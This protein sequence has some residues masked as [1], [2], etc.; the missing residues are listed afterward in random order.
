MTRLLRECIPPR[1]AL[2]N[3]RGKMGF[4]ND[5]DADSTSYR[6]KNRVD[7]DVKTA[8]IRSP[9]QDRR[10]RLSRSSGSAIILPADTSPADSAEYADP[11]RNCDVR[12]TS[13]AGPVRPQR[14]PPLTRRPT[15][16][17]RAASVRK[18]RTGHCTYFRNA[19]KQHCLW[20]RAGQL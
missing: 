20:R 3:L 9:F 7:F 17:G 6:H 18:G 5:A 2:S 12:M 15:R 13:L 8:W 11:T 1:A 16:R 4:C 10:W 14:A 19:K